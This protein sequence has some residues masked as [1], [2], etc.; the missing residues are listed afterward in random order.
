MPAGRFVATSREN[1]D[2]SGR[3][4]RRPLTQSVDV[5]RSPDEG[6]G[7]GQCQPSYREK[8]Q[9]DDQLYQRVPLPS[10]RSYQAHGA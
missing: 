9:G 7:A 2:L 4:S 8:E 5:E 10:D 3:D 1:L 6:A